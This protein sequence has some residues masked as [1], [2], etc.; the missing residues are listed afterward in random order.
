MENQL[1]VNRTDL[2]SALSD[3]TMVASQSA[4]KKLAFWKASSQNH[5]KHRFLVNVELMLAQR[6]TAGGYVSNTYMCSCSP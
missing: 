3:R 5:L 6:S 2:K 1:S 4:S